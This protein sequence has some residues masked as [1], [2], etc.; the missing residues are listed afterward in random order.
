[1]TSTRGCLPEWS[2]TAGSGTRRCA[3]AR[4][5]RRAATGDRPR[6]RRRP[7]R[8]E[9][10]DRYAEPAPRA[11]LEALDDEQAP[12]HR[13]TARIQ[14]VTIAR[15]TALLRS[16][17]DPRQQHDWDACGTF[18]VH[19]SFGS[20]RLGVPHDLAHRRVPEDARERGLCVVTTAYRQ[21]PPPDEW[22]SMLLTLRHDP[23]RFFRVANVLRRERHGVGRAARLAAY[24]QACRDDRALDA[25]YLAH[26]VSALGV[27]ALGVTALGPHPITEPLAVAAAV[28]VLRHGALDPTTDEAFRGRHRGLLARGRGVARSVGDHRLRSWIRTTPRFSAHRALA[29]TAGADAALVD[30]PDLDR[31]ADALVAAEA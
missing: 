7:I 13:Q 17:L 23:D 24:Q 26:D 20:V 31:I 9:E 5:R 30:P 27:T 16:L 21:I 25:A 18:W 14:R 11:R 6:P 28:L 4:P 2:P 29:G 12:F 19:G 8:V 22:T 15:A 3:G 1:M 10:P